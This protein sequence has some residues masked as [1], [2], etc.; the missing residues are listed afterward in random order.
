[1]EQ[2]ATV[3]PRSVAD[4]MHEL[5]ES[6]TEGSKNSSPHVPHVPPIDVMFPPGGP[7]IGLALGIGSNDVANLEREAEDY[8]WDARSRKLVQTP[9]ASPFDIE[10]IPVRPVFPLDLSLLLIGVP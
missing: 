8:Q 1:V 10:V 3:P 9:R 6:L 5:D 2:P 4:M 7:G